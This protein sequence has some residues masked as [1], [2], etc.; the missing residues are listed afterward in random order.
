[1]GGVLHVQMG[2]DGSGRDSDCTLDNR[3]SI[4]AAVQ[5]HDNEDA[6]RRFF[7][8]Y[9]PMIWNLA[10]DMGL[11]ESDA[12]SVVQEAMIAAI[13]ALRA[14]SYDPS[15][16]S[17]KGFLRG[18]IRN[19]VVDKLRR[20]YKQAGLGNGIVPIE[21]LRADEPSLWEAYEREWERATLQLCLDQVRVDVAPQTY[22]AFDLY[23]LKEWPA[24]KV[25]DFLDI[26]T[27]AVYIAKSRVLSRLRTCREELDRWEQ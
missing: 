5:D 15:R 20:R 7:A 9:A 13:K 19:K 22:Q 18:I 24:E 1:M 17:F 21:A 2:P 8:R 16:G 6:W 26:T 25:A 23:V 12:D 11:H 3:T 4:I 14:D 27:N 10:R